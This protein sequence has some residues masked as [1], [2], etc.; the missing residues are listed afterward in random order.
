MRG[1]VPSGFARE[2]DGPSLIASDRKS[3]S[4]KLPLSDSSLLRFSLVGIRARLLGPDVPC[5]FL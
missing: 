2:T 4:V 5:R 3:F 1:S